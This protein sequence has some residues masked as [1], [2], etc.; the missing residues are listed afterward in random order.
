M[1]DMADLTRRCRLARDYLYS[2]KSEGTPVTFLLAGPEVEAV[3]VTVWEVVSKRLSS[4]FYSTYQ[5]FVNDVEPLKYALLNCSTRP[6]KKRTKHI[7]FV[8]RRFYEIASNTST[9][10]RSVP[11]TCCANPC[12]SVVNRLNSENIVDVVKAFHSSG[13]LCAAELR[14]RV[15]TVKL[16]NNIQNDISNKSKSHTHNGKSVSG[17]KSSGKFYENTI[18]KSPF[19]LHNEYH[20]VKELITAHDGDG[21]ETKKGNRYYAFITKTSGRSRGASSCTVD[22]QQGG[23]EDPVAA[24]R[25]HD[26]AT[27]RASGPMACRR[28]GSPVEGEDNSCLINFEIASYAEEDMT[29]FTKWD[30]VLISG[31][32]AVGTWPGVQPCDFSFLLFSSRKKVKLGERSSS[33]FVDKVEIIEVD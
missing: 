18:N 26:L 20:G 1:S 29:A 15:G 23:F 33:E 28:Q 14:S 8:F 7:E 25:A 12:M 3:A 19:R 9:S 21:E 24:A 5:E 4:N 27:I 31:L 30:S 32:S 17:P 6:T 10:N 16:D 2:T 22:L 11:H 13:E